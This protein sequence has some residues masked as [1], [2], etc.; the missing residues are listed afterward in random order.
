MTSDAIVLP[1]Q[2]RRILAS[3]AQQLLR[4]LHYKV[5]WSTQTESKVN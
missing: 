3:K 5:T 1:D 4:H 2:I